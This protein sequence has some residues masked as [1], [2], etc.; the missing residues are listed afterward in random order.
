M[1]ELAVN[2][3]APKTADFD[4]PA[5]FDVS[6]FV[7]LPFQYGPAAEEFVATLSFDAESS[8]R[9]E[10]L[11]AGQ[12]VLENAR[13]GVLWRVPARCLDRLLRFAIENGPGLSVVDPPAALARLREGLAETEVSHG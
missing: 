6:R 4:R 11:S 13:D 8:W 2:A 5:D 1:D 10:S 9:A 3:S 7:R 12:G